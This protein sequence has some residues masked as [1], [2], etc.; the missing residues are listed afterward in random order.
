[1]PQLEEQISI[2]KRPTDVFRLSHDMDGRATWDERVARVQVLTQKPVRTGTVVR[3]DTRPAIGAVFSWEGEFVDYSYPSSSRVKV[4]D[5]APSSYFAAG[6]E[7]WRLEGSDVGTRFTLT[8]D[9][10]PRGLIGRIIDAFMRRRATRRAI[11]RSLENLKE[12][13]EARP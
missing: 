7:E 1:M 8:W 12:M 10:A 2:S 6:Y 5:A 11:K 4:I 3:I 13:V 9:Y